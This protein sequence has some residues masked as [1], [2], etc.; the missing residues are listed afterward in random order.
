LSL[1]TRFYGDLAASTNK[2]RVERS[3]IRFCHRVK[4][5]APIVIAD[6]TNR[7]S[8]RRHTALKSEDGQTL[9]E[10]SLIGALIAVVL[11]AVLMT[12]EGQIGIALGY[13]GS[14]F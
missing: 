13:V 2:S 3:E 10:Y 6:A 5:R 1:E 12:F 14:W 11:A 8:P 9:V 4:G 7:T